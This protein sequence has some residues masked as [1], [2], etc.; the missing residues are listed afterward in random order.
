MHTASH[1][2]ARAQWNPT[3]K[4]VVWFLWLGPPRVRIDPTRVCADK[5]IARSCSWLETLHLACGWACSDEHAT[6]ERRLTATTGTPS[7]A[8]PADAPKG[9]AMRSAEPWARDGIRAW[10]GFAPGQPGS[11]QVQAR[12]GR[13]GGQS[14][15]ALRRT[16][17]LATLKYLSIVVSRTSQ[18]SSLHPRLSDGPGH[19]RGGLPRKNTAATPIADDR[20][21]QNQPTRSPTPPHRFRPVG[22]SS[23]IPC[24][25]S[26]RER[27]GVSKGTL[28]GRSSRRY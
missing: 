4:E 10:E 7:Y 6:P 27:C 13:P 23:S 14:K 15:S 16:R 18:D 26:S 25:V 1:P 2:S 22:S 11:R 5:G 24:H 8:T 19:C 12:D 20:Q 28:T 21:P 17:Y 9:S 3:R